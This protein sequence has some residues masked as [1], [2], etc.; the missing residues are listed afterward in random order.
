MRPGS[1]LDALKKDGRLGGAD[2]LKFH[3]II[4]AKTGYV[5]VAG[6]GGDVRERG[7]ACL[8]SQI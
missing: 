5:L 1:F 2:G 4:K 7:V 3:G 6:V 8:I